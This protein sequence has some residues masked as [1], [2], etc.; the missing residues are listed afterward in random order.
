MSF[1]KILMLL[2]TPLPSGLRVPLYRMLGAKIGKNV[3]LKPFG[4]VIADEIEIGRDSYIDPLTMVFNIKKLCLGRA[5]SIRF[6]SMV[7]GHGGGS[8]A[9]GDFSTLG[10]FTMVNCTGNFSAGKYFGTGPRCMIYTHGNHLP[11][12]MGYKNQIRDVKAGDFVWLHMNVIVLPGVTMGDHVMVYSHG[13]VSKDLPDDTTLV[14]PYK[15]Q[16]QFKTSRARTPV[17]PE[18]EQE[19]YHHVWD[20]LEEYVKSFYKDGEVKR[21]G[22][23]VELR[24]GNKSIHLF[25]GAKKE[26]PITKDG[27]L[28]CF[29]EG[30]E[31]IYKAHQ[32]HNW[33]DFKNSL[34]HFPRYHPLFKDVLYYLEFYKAQYF[35]GYESGR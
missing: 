35:F 30:N 17:T 27:A 33:L 26:T 7:Y 20:K 12:L 10:L 4:L 6:G 18:F 3:H 1:K 2:S 34:Y 5:A 28:V 14:P 16:I 31:G 15:E 23:S 8:F 32:D 11:T 13:V 19:W 25:D 24:I 9:M 21:N 22:G 29:L